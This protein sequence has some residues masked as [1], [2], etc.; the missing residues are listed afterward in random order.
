MPVDNTTLDAMLGTYRNMLKEIKEQGKE[1]EDVLVMEQTLSRMEQ[2]GSECADVMEF[3]GKLMQE[4]LF[5]K[6]SDHYGRA[7]TNN[8]GST[9][10]TSGEYTEQTDKALLEQSLKALRDAVKRIKEGKE[11]TKKLMGAQAKDADVLFKEKTIT[12]AIEKLILLGESG[13]SYPEFLRIQIEQGLDKA[14]EGSAMTR[15]GQ[16]YLLEASKALAVNPHYIKKDEEKLALFDELM[17][18][19]HAGIPNN[20]EYSLACDKI[21]WR[22]E[23]EIIKWNKIKEVWEKVLYYLDEWITSFC[24]Y[25][26][27]IEPWSMATNPKDAVI[28]SQDCVPGK[29]RVWEKIAFRYFS[30][31]LRDLFKHE[32]FRWDVIHH[33]LW[34][35]QEYVEFLLKEVE[36]ICYPEAKPSSE[37]ISKAENFRNQNKIAS[38]DS[39]KPALRY[40]KCF[41]S[42]FGSGEYE[43]RFGE[44][45]PPNTKASAWNLEAFSI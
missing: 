35:S 34:W 44:V 4:N 18:N 7:L 20:I 13:I 39:H 10:D 40:A 16:V 3:S 17:K 9:V 29:L 42:Y 6:F 31:P 43:K 23:P 45:K 37:L 36:P 15:D 24:S 2:L 38:P 22:V 28:E 33:H 8:G 19:S 12:D 21:D 25:A 27:S 11:E 41:D 26:P 1:G 5:M 30:I 32:T 14:M